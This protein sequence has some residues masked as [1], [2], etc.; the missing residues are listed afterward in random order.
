[1]SRWLL[2]L[3]GEEQEERDQLLPVVS[4]FNHTARC[5]EID[6]EIQTLLCYSFEIRGLRKEWKS[7]LVCSCLQ[8]VSYIIPSALMFDLLY[9]KPHM[10]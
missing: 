4:R 3:A 1:M 9:G 2:A 7:L 8:A 6:I 10:M 5:D